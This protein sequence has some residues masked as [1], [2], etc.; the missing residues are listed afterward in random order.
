MERKVRAPTMASQREVRAPPD[1][2]ASRRECRRS[3][4]CAPVRARRISGAIRCARSEFSGRRGLQAARSENFFGGE[5]SSDRGAC[6]SSR[7]RRGSTRSG[8]GTRDANRCAC[9]KPLCHM[10]F[11]GSVKFPRAR[12]AHIGRKH[13]RTWRARRRPH[14]DCGGGFRR[15]QFVKRSRCFSHCAVVIGVQCMSIRDCTV[16]KS[17]SLM[18]RRAVMAKRAKSKTK[19]AAKKTAKKTKRKTTRRK[20]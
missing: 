6:R 10:A 7:G 5:E 11:R 14:G 12:C 18:A 16:P 20:K 2:V 1:R 15:P 3:M 19:S 9:R 8:S 13:R 4:G 17:P